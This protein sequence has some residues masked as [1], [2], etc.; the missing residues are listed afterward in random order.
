MN[1][2]R[3]TPVQSQSS[4]PPVK[5]FAVPASAPGSTPPN[6]CFHFSSAHDVDGDGAVTAS[7]VLHQ[8]PC[9]TVSSEART[10]TTSSFLPAGSVP[11]VVVRSASDLSSASVAT[12]GEGHRASHLAALSA[13]LTSA[14]GVS[15][16]TNVSLTGEAVASVV[17]EAMGSSFSHSPTRTHGWL[18]HQRRPRRMP[19]PFP[20]A[21]SNSPPLCARYS[22]GESVAIAS[23]APPGLQESAPPLAHLASPTAD[24]TPLA[25]PVCFHSLCHT[26]PPTVAATTPSSATVLQVPSSGPAPAVHCRGGNMAAALRG[27]PDALSSSAPPVTGTAVG[28]TGV[29]VALEAS[30]AE[31][32]RST[33]ART[34]SSFSSYHTTRPGSPFTTSVLAQHCGADSSSSTVCHAESH[35]HLNANVGRGNEGMMPPVARRPL[36]DAAVGDASRACGSVSRGAAVAKLADA[37]VHRRGSLEISSS[38]A[39]VSGHTVPMANAGMRPDFML[40]IP[41]TNNVASATR[42]P[43]QCCLSS[44]LWS[45]VG[46]QNRQPEVLSGRDNSSVC[47]GTSNTHSGVLRDARSGGCGSHT[48]RVVGSPLRFPFS[49]EFSKATATQEGPIKSSPAVFG[50][51]PWSAVG[52][53]SLAVGDGGAATSRAAS[54][55]VAESHGGTVGGDEHAGT[56]PLLPAAA[57]AASPAAARANEVNPTLLVLSGAPRVCN[58]ECSGHHTTAATSRR[59]S[60]TRDS[61]CSSPVAQQAASYGRIYKRAPVADQFS[62]LTGCGKSARAVLAA[63]YDGANK[64]GSDMSKSWNASGSGGVA[65][66]PQVP[67]TGTGAHRNPTHAFRVHRCHTVTATQRPQHERSSA[68]S[69]TKATEEK[70]HDPCDEGVQKRQQQAWRMAP[71]SYP[72]PPAHPRDGPTVVASLQRF[73]SR[74]PTSSPLDQH[75]PQSRSRLGK[76]DGASLLHPLPSTSSPSLFASAATPSPA[77]LEVVPPPPPTFALFGA[78]ER[79][80]R[81]SEM[82]QLCREHADVLDSFLDRFTLQLHRHSCTP[83]LLFSGASP[84]RS[85]SLSPSSLAPSTAHDDVEFLR[86]HRIIMYLL[87]QPSEVMK[88]GVEFFSD[89]VNSWPLHMLYLTCCFY[90]AACERGFGALTTALSKGGIV[91]SG[92][93]L[94]AALAVSMAQSE[95]EL[96]RSTACMYRAA[97]YTGVLMRKRHQSFET[98]TRL[99]TTGG[100][101]LL[102]VN[103]PIITLR[104]LVARVNEGYDVFASMRDT[105]KENE[106]MR[107]SAWFSPNSN[108]TTLNSGTVSTLPGRRGARPYSPTSSCGYASVSSPLTRSM[109]HNPHSVIEVSRVISSRAAVLCG[110]PLD[111]LRLDTILTRFAEF[112]DLKIHKEYL[113]AGGP[114]NSRFFNKHMAH[115]LMGLWKARGVSFSLAS[116]QL[117]LYSPVNGDSWTESLRMPFEHPAPPDTS[118]TTMASAHDSNAVFSSSATPPT[119]DYRDEWWMFSVAEAATCANQDLTYSLRHMRDGSVLLDFSTHAMRIGRLI[120]WTNKSITV[121]AVPENCHE[122][123]AMPPPRRSPKDEAVRNTMEKL[124]IINDVLREVGSN[125]EQPPDALANPSVEL[126]TTFTELGLLE[127]LQGPQELAGACRSGAPMQAASTVLNER[128]G[129]Q[130]RNSSTG[131][132]DVASGVGVFSEACCAGREGAAHT[133]GEGHSGGVFSTAPAAGRRVKT[134]TAAPVWKSSSG[135][136]AT[137]NILATENPL[138]ITHSIGNRHT[139]SLSLSSTHGVGG[140]SGLANALDRSMETSGCPDRH[141]EAGGAA[142]VPM[143]VFP[144]GNTASAVPSGHALTSSTPVQPPAPPFTSSSPAAVRATRLLPPSVVHGDRLLGSSTAT[145]ATHLFLDMTMMSMT[146]PNSVPSTVPG[147]NTGATHAGLDI[148]PK[149]QSVTYT[150][151]DDDDGCTSRMR[152]NSRD[153]GAHEHVAAASNTSGVLSGL[154]CELWHTVSPIGGSDASSEQRTPTT[155]TISAGAVASMQLN[156]EEASVVGG[157][158]LSAP[159]MPLLPVP[160]VACPQPTSLSGVRRCDS[161]VVISASLREA[162]APAFFFPSDGFM[163]RESEPE[164]A[165]EHRIPSIRS[166]RSSSHL[167]VP[168]TDFSLQMRGRRYEAPA[169]GDHP[170]FSRGDIFALDKDGAASAA[171]S[172][173]P[174]PPPSPAAGCLPLSQYENEFVLRRSNDHVGIVNVYQ[175]SAL[176]KYYEMQFNCVLCDGAV[177]FAGLLKKKSGMAFPSYTL[178]LCPTVF[179]LLE[180]WDGYEFEELW[181]RSLGAPVCSRITSPISAGLV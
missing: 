134:N 35:V 143:N 7:G 21:P 104:R 20:T 82:V 56:V 27:S 169:E 154:E 60:L 106:A 114:E 87:R 10:M 45:S 53:G 96:I 130:Q 124:A 43:V 105:Y 51:Q 83:P 39:S 108:S 80:S 18:A 139:N 62:P 174:G 160:Q 147:D 131:A 115:E 126:F 141:V 8:L 5:S 74:I 107:G 89:A 66:A 99:T 155:K 95:E 76:G 173:L 32:L 133:P 52:R 40:S 19:H 123:S 165:S 158:S 145:G 86:W 38:H 41:A 36:A 113:P 168:D 68:A 129:H 180:L 63:A 156:V 69:W 17:N 94:F 25:L 138:N 16:L 64:S 67:L 111:M 142:E 136:N 98:E 14:R 88:V 121:L 149:S 59:G 75:H 177:L 42:G 100:F 34:V 92:K 31:G 28:N 103:I 81:F 122:A 137:A 84:A 152:S 181:K 117:P 112:N 1:S 6:T 90:V 23:D 9:S 170:H 54:G 12:T 135:N 11:K 153:A 163:R 179:S 71:Q 13:A 73:L 157:V 176:I 3:D 120:A 15:P 72:E 151:D 55:T 46:L 118:T 24:S 146:P 49:G 140:S 70:T 171:V 125:I 161:A 162:P 58:G 172:C 159:P 47:S 33:A 167:Q 61:G 30:L 91:C 22:S 164:L 97:F 119:E 93:G 101:T 166:R 150:A 109:P 127:V 79:L 29:S 44:P 128:K 110:H 37:A 2:S 65:E 116:V 78:L 50:R 175:V 4:S 77:P 85:Q 57:A 102:V 26:T 144:G 132:G 148:H 178:L 48:E